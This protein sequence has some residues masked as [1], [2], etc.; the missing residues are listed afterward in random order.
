LLLPLSLAPLH[1]MLARAA[2]DTP[3]HAFSRHAA[4][5]FI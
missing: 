3:C 2:P 4:D 5:Y 1:A